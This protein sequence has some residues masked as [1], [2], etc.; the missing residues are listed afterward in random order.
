MYAINLNIE[1]QLIAESFFHEL[2]SFDTAVVH[3]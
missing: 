2:F 1:K 3:F